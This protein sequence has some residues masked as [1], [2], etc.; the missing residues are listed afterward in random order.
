MGFEAA[1]GAV[2]GGIVTGLMAA[3]QH[4]DE[5]AVSSAVEALHAVVKDPAAMAAANE[6]VVAAQH[7]KAKRVLADAAAARAVKA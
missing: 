6:L 1:L 5:A 4:G 2:V 7:A 3:I